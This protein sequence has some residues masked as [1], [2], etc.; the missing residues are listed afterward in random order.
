MLR[1]GFLRSLFVLTLIFGETIIDLLW[2]DLMIFIM[3]TRKVKK[4]RI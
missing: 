1:A 3:K 2:T 4:K